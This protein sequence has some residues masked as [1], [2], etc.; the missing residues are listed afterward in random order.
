LKAHDVIIKSV[1]AVYGTDYPVTPE[2]EDI[3]WLTATLVQ[4]AGAE[5]AEGKLGVAWVIMNRA[6][7]QKKRVPDVVLAPWQFSCWNTNSPTKRLI[8]TRLTSTWAAC[9][10]AARLA[11]NALAP[12]PTFGSTHYLN[13]S[14]LPRLPAWYAKNKV[15]AILGR[16]HFL[17]VE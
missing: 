10:E 17:Q 8:T 13:P 12:D 9:E 6:E 15:R 16:H 5:P 7:S 4:E 11:Y 2:D 3:Y 1:H 14:V